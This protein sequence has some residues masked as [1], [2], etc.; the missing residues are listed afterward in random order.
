MFTK[1][2][3]NHAGQDEDQC[4]CEPLTQEA[5]Q[6][7]NEE[8]LEQQINLSL[9]VQTVMQWL[10]GQRHKPLLP[11]ERAYFKIH[12]RFEHHCQEQMPGHRICYPLVS[13][14]TNTITL[15]VAHM[16]TYP[17]FRDVMTVAIRMSRGFVR[18]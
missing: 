10:T 14:C 17:E 4:V 11:S 9:S 6:S 8:C 15:P 18:V 16:N 1:C 13:A 7:Q 5:P 3:F 12:V 2:F